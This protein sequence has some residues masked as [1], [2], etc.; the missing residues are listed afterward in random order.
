MKQVQIT[1]L[2]WEARDGQQFE[3]ELKA[4]M[5]E[6]RSHLQGVGD[7]LGVCWRELSLDEVITMIF[8]NADT[9]ALLLTEKA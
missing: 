5:H 3:S 2:V 4:R 6:L 8:H 9:V 7:N 1:K